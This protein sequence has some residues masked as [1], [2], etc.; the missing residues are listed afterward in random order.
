MYGRLMANVIVH[1]SA[2]LPSRTPEIG[3]RICTQ[4]KQY[5]RNRLAKNQIRILQ[6]LPGWTWD[7]IAGKWEEMYAQTR[8]YAE[9]DDLNLLPTNHKFYSWVGGQRQRYKKGELSD[10][11]IKKLLEISGWSWDPGEDEWIKIYHQVKN[12]YA[13][14]LESN[15]E[16]KKEFGQWI[17]WQRMKY[18]QG[19]LK[20]ERIRMLEL[21]TNWD[22][23]PETTKWEENLKLLTKI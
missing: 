19:A 17:N 20:P 11:Q 16:D 18:R 12:M 5:K 2:N 21:I 22:W 6:D 9:N 8:R 13:S 1:G 4:R 23:N 3:E 15:E 14:S 7:P 10:Y